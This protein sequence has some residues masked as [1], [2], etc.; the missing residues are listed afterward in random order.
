MP[1][2]NKQ[3]KYR[4][5]FI[6]FLLFSYLNISFVKG[7]ND[8]HDHG[9]DEHH[10]EFDPGATAIHH[11]SDANV[12]SILDAVRI[13]LPMILYSYDKGL[14]IFS[15]GK[16]HA[17]H[18]EDGHSSYNGY[19]L[20]HGSVHRVVDSGFPMEGS[21]EIEGFAH[22]EEEDA[23]GKKRDIYFAKYQGKEFRLDA[24]S[25]M[26]GGILG[27][28]FTSFID[29]S[30]TK[31]V[32][33]MILVSLFL[34]WL[35]RG[36]AVSYRNSPDKAPKGAQGILE[37]ILLFIRDDVAI[38]FI[39]KKY[40]KFLPFLLSVFFFILG[41]NLWGQVPFL[42]SVNVTGSLSVTMVLAILVFILVNFN[43]NGH[44]WGHIFWMPGVP[45]PI[46]IL[47]ACV[48]VMGL[49]IKPL[50]LMLRLAGNISA[51]HIAILSFIG[52]IFIFGKS[53]ES[54]GGSLVGT[55]VSIPL[56]MF[57]MAIEII[58]AFV[59]A[60][61][62]TILTASFIGAAT[63]EHHHDHEHAEGHH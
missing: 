6:A 29:F 49:F 2:K 19:V 14:E 32:V 23:K 57:M 44:Y 45:V 59:Q 7:A 8:G 31:N 40:S 25:T 62:F 61:V 22:K 15:S 33:S 5:I 4:I 52:L 34:F 10:A 1:N 9:H 51:G 47:L 27:G 16:F 38:P 55:A 48:E 54:L 37:P 60:F 28:G 13:P 20:H 36:A 24:R 39:G 3:M 17:G 56:T 18:H 43:G 35:F 21:V 46:K 42:G 50:T 53:G 30:I 63:E 41:L 58:V 11:I 26:D 12:Y